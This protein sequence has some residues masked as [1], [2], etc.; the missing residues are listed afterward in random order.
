MNTFTFEK[1]GK[2]WFISA[3]EHNNPGRAPQTP[4]TEGSPKWLNTLARGSQ[5]VSVQ[6][7]TKPFEGADQL[8]LM[9]HGSRGGGY[10]LMKT[11]N[12]RPVN[13]RLWICDVALFVFGD[14]PEGLYFKKTAVES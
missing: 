13:K 1:Q 10:Y 9:E 8:E 6:L 2:Q 7:D 12:G 5:T 11:L 3:P 4:L 14:I